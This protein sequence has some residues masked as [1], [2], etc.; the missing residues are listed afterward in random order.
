MTRGERILAWV[1]NLLVP[2]TGLILD[3]RLIL[4]IAATVAWAAL[5]A[6]LL[7]VVFVVPQEEPRRRLLFLVAAAVYAVAQWLLVVRMRRRAA[8]AAGGERDEQFKAALPAYVQGRLDDA[9]AAC[10]ALLRAD[11]DDVEA[12]LQL[13][14]IAR[15]RG[16]V[17][18]ARRYLR[19]ARYLDD[20]GRWDFEIERELA[21]V[22]AARTPSV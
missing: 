9:Q 20:A 15:R 16:D 14:T 19:R 18:R 13:A 21:A 12:T 2:G 7:L 10:K 22:G 3:G 1:M 17:R 6:G 4:G 5:A 11:A 8:L